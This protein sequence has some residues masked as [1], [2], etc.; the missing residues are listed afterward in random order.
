[1]VAVIIER[2]NKSLKECFGVD[3]VNDV[4]AFGTTLG[5]FF[6]NNYS[7]A[8]EKVIELPSKDAVAYNKSLTKFKNTLKK[9]PGETVAVTF[10]DVFFETVKIRK[11]AKE[12]EE[13]ILLV[14]AEDEVFLCIMNADA[15]LTFLAENND[16]VTCVFSKIKSKIL[17][18]KYVKI[19]DNPLK[20]KDFCNDVLKGT[21]NYRLPELAQ[22][23]YVSS[24]IPEGDFVLIPPVYLGDDIQIEK[25]CVIG[26]FAIVSD[27]CLIA[28]N[29]NVRKSILGEN[30]YISTGC[31]IEGSLLSDNVVIRRNSVVFNDSVLC[32]DA[33]VGEEQ[34]VENHSFIRAFCRV[35]EYDRS[36]VNYRDDVINSADGFYGY[37][38]EKAAL[39]GAATGISF[40]M[41]RIAVASDGEMNSTALKL[42]FLGGLM[43][44][45]AACYDFGNTFFSSLQYCMA[46]CELDCGV[47][48]RGSDNGTVISIFKR[49]DTSLLK[50]DFYNIR[51][52]IASR[53]I[54]RCDKKDCKNIRQ[55][56]GMQRMYIQYLTSLFTDRIN[57][58]PVF[59]CENKRI[60]SVA[61]LAANKIGFKVGKDR[62]IF[63]INPVGTRVSAQSNG[64]VFPYTKLLEAVSFYR[65]KKKTT[66]SN[67]FFENDSVI[68][69]FLLIKIM[70]E[71]KVGLQKIIDDLP[72]FYVAEKTVDNCCELKILAADLSRDNKIDFKKDEIFYFDGI[73]SVKINGNQKGSVSIKARSHSMETAT[74]IIDKLTRFITER[75]YYTY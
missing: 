58:T 54:P 69:S 36:V 57:F 37:T 18:E 53:S 46:F 64:V 24:N 31:Q 41:P 67:D 75:G 66:Y 49:G 32:H 74:E 59:V 34:I 3:S 11:I 10:S 52:V 14:N 43:T 21:V 73:N 17:Y 9:Q 12:N 30:S 2:C 50:S 51:S 6:N 56:H 40:D 33:T 63:N 47:F 23:I 13:S 65:R 62:V 48:I 39:L 26:P 20:F 25:G 44:T 70:S 35:E 1:M 7:E 19:I 72:R 71:E 55:I 22:G 45:G 60:L 38:P 16:D 27:G 8:F 4:S 42:A 5:Y 15:L 61:E 28:R 68:L 29:S